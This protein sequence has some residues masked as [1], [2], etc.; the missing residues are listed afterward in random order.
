MN[1][2]S[3]ERRKVKNK[4]I[5]QTTFIILI[6]METKGRRKSTSRRRSNVKLFSSSGRDLPKNVSQLNN[7]KN[8]TFTIFGRINEILEETI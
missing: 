5:R 7:T 4:L 8:T 1:H 2:V 3:F 6:V